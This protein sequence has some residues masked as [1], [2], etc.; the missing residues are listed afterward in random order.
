MSVQV[1]LY[2]FVFLLIFFLFF[3]LLLRDML[4]SWTLFMDLFIYFWKNSSSC[5]G[6]FKALLLGIY[7][8]VIVPSFWLT[9]FIILKYSICFGNILWTEVSL[10]CPI[11]I[12]TPSFF[13]LVFAWCIFSQHFTYNLSVFLYLKS[14][15][16]RQH[17][18]G[19]CFLFALTVPVFHYSV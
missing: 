4:I 8:P 16:R 2:S 9:D 6:Y 17:I 1:G 5:F 12:I 18:I 3:S 14:I 13:W 7:L 15:S 10:I 11:S 19:A